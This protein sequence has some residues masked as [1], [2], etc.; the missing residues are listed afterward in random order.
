MTGADIERARSA[1]F[2]LDAGCDRSQW[3]RLGMAA[4][5]AGLSLEDF[6]AWS[7]GAPNFKSERDCAAAWRSF[8]DGPV[9]AA[10]LFVEAMAAGWRD[11]ERRNG[12]QRPH[13]EVEAERRAA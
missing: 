9:K 1:L 8:T 5:D 13:A 10:T 2:H 12:H 7:G 11:P 3:V 6:A 4:K